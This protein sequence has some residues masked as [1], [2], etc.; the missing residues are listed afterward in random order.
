MVYYPAQYIPADEVLVR[1]PRQLAQGKSGSLLSQICSCWNT[2]VTTSCLPKAPWDQSDRVTL[3]QTRRPPLTRH[4][5]LH[6]WVATFFISDIIW[7]H[8]IEYV[9]LL[10]ERSLLSWHS[11][12]AF[13]C[14]SIKHNNSSNYVILTK[15]AQNVLST[16]TSSKAVKF[17]TAE[18]NN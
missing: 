7:H 1:V 6:P 8:R 13:S 16:R 14:H 10:G 5:A 2:Y 17:H 12:E 4:M 15:Q 3:L 18:V 11:A 9:E